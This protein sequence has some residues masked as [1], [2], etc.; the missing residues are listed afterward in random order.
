MVLL[1]GEIDLSVAA[2]SVFC[3]VVMAVLSE[4]YGVSALVAIL[5]GLL[6]GAVVGFINGFFVAVPRVPSFIVTLA[7]SIFYSGL[8]LTLL[9][10]QVLDHQ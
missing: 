2:V 8:L 6:A 4:R 3:S 7:A 5:A 9:A 1:L 10:P